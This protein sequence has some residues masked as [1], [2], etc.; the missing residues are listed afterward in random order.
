M[1]QQ[2]KEYKKSMNLL[3]SCLRNGVLQEIYV[4]LI[5]HIT[6]NQVHKINKYIKQIVI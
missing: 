4:H 3:M 2:D 5:N 6:I 1:D